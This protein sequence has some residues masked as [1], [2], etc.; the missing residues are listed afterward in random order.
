[1]TTHPDRV[2]TTQRILDVWRAE[3]GPRTRRWSLLVSSADV[4]LS[5][6]LER[7][8]SG[9]GA[10][11]ALLALQAIDAGL[12]GAS[13]SNAL[14][15]CSRAARRQGSGADL[16]ALLDLVGGVETVNDRL[17]RARLRS[18][19]AA[20]GSS[21]L[22]GSE[23]AE[24]MAALAGNPLYA[25]ALPAFAADAPWGLAAYLVADASFWHAQ[26]TGPGVRL[27]GGVLVAPDGSELIVQMLAE[28]DAAPAALD[29][30]VLAAAG[31]AFALTLRLLGH[32]ELALPI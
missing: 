28:V 21:L 13:L 26:G 1:M 30:P 6:E 5:H 18:R 22:F 10:A 29:D 15:L 12:S 19:F 11:S 7:P 32:D 31:R 2:A 3:L 27:D 25:P 23:Q 17:R 4:E 16:R 9:D 8:C 14:G 24:A 20:D